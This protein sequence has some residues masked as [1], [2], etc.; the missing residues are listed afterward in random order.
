M[1]SQKTTWTVK[2][3]QKQAKQAVKE[4]HQRLKE[5]KKAKQQVFVF[6]NLS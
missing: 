2:M 3:E 1:K 6:S 4:L 5:E